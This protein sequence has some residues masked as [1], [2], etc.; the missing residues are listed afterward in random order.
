MR[1]SR[2]EILILETDH[3]PS[4]L[5]EKARRLP[6]SRPL[7]VHPNA[8]VVVTWSSYYTN[9]GWLSWAAGEHCD[10]SA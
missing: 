2:A 10:P 6:Q 4:M 3:A 1:S 9:I 8:G 7:V 5:I